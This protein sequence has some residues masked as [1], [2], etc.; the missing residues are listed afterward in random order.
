LAN[1]S[2][3]WKALT[4]AQQ[5]AWA[6]A[7][8]NFPFLDRFG[9]PYT[10]TGFNLFMQTNLLQGYATGS[11]ITTAPTLEGTGA[12]WTPTY[13]GPA[14]QFRFTLTENSGSATVYTIF[15]STPPLPLGQTTPRKRYQYVGRNSGRTTTGT[16]NLTT[17]WGA[18]FGT[19]ASGLRVFWRVTIRNTNSP[20]ILGFATGELTT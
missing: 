11:V 2:L 4:I 6:A 15:E 3:R 16:V 17:A 1:L 20:E 14:G 10:G 19:P 7:A 13:V 12:A 8:P 18:L 9:N 5:N